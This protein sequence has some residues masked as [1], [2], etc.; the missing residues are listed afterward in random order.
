M[1]RF[2][3]YAVAALAVIAAAGW[4]AYSSYSVVRSDFGGTPAIERL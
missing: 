4:Y 1:R 3:P 2:V